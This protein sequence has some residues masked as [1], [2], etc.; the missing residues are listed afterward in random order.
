MTR[1]ETT[2]RRLAEDLSMMGWLRTTNLRTAETSVKTSAKAAFARLS[3]A[4][5]P[6]ARVIVWRFRVPGKA[7]PSL[8]LYVVRPGRP[9]PFVT[10]RVH[11]HFLVELTPVS[12]LS[13]LVKIQNPY[14][15]PH[16]SHPHRV[17]PLT[18]IWV[19]VY[20]GNILSQM[21]FSA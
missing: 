13:K 9:S 10:E 2:R 14:L 1:G 20:K 11:A 21:H 16:P 3:A 17:L 8:I 5:Q 18:L 12:L 15:A 4:C 6:D 7:G 19:D